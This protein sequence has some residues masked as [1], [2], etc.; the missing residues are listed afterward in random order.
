ML[1]FTY[2]LVHNVCVVFLSFQRA[3]AQHN[4]FDHGGL[5]QN[6]RDPAARW[7][8][9]LSQLWPWWSNWYRCL[10]RGLVQQPELPLLR[11]GPCLRGLF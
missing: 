8:V 6:V 9:L 2:R 4:V 11:D 10:R 3:R 5:R 7:S 1:P